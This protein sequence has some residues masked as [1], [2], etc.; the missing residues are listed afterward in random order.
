MVPTIKMAF[1][2]VKG[3]RIFRAF[4]VPV[5]T[6]RITIQSLYGNTLSCHRYIKCTKDASTLHRRKSH[7]DCGNHQSL[8]SCLTEKTIPKLYHII[9]KV[10]RPKTRPFEPK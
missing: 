10:A 6:Q 9:N 3:G 2:P 8:L 4:D 5:T 7:L 1:A